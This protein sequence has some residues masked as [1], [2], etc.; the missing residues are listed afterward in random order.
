MVEKRARYVVTFQTMKVIFASLLALLAVSCADVLKRQT[1]NTNCNDMAALNYINNVNPEI[2]DSIN[3]TAEQTCG[4]DCL[5]QGCTF[6]TNNG[7]TTLCLSTIAIGCY[8]GLSGSGTVAASCQRCF[9]S[10]VLTHYLTLPSSCNTQSGDFNTGDLC[11][12]E[13]AGTICTY[14]RDN[15]Y[16]ADCRTDL[17][18]LC[19][20][21]A[22]TVC[23]SD[24]GPTQAT[25]GSDSGPTQATGG[26]DSGPTQTTGGSGPT[27]ATGGSDSGPTQT[28]GGSG[29]PTQATGGSD[30]GPTQQATGGSPSAT[31]A[32]KE[33]AV[34][35]LLVVVFLIF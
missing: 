23:Q 16:P 14:Y 4:D 30:S 18:Q 3:T 8:T 17:A 32:M 15:G 1:R 25:G 21:A 34:L 31:V 2:C 10:Q 22:P 12:D 27:Q 13:C 11:S 29:R 24:S 20:S 7:Y 33:V 28:T 9:D 5:G 6:Y 26:S 19:G 35:I